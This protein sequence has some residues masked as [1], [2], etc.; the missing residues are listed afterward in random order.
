MI[1]AVYDNAAKAE[2]LFR[3]CHTCKADNPALKARQVGTKAVITTTC[4][5][6]KCPKQVQTWHSQ[7][8]MP[9]SC[10]AAG[11]FLLCMAILLA[12]GSVTKVSHIFTHMGLGCVS[13]NTFFKYQ[14]VSY[15]IHSGH[16]VVKGFLH[17]VI[18]FFYSQKHYVGVLMKCVLQL[19]D[20][21]T[22]FSIN[23][24]LMSNCQCV[25]LCLLE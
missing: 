25:M 2:L 9:N 15:L 4:S 24:K 6:R 13:L 21:K 7:P 11:N 17:E 12:G 18:H 10:I 16:Q 19:G 3:F 22:I 14:R 20:N 1:F 5:N 8:D 23:F